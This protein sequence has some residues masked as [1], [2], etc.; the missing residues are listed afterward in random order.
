MQQPTSAVDCN[1]DVLDEIFTSWAADTRAHDTCLDTDG[2]D[3][4]TPN[5]PGKQEHDGDDDSNHNPPIDETASSDTASQNTSL[6]VV[7]PVSVASP[8]IEF[9]IPAFAEFSDQ[10]NRRALIDHFT[11][12]LSHL[13]VLR[14]D[15]GNPFQRLVLPLSQKSTAVSNSIFAL[16]SAHLEHRG[17]HNSERSVYFHNKAINGLAA[18]IAKGCDANR[19]ELL[20][21]IILL[22]YYE[23]VSYARYPVVW[24][25]SL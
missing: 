5:D 13:I 10:A 1:Q 4:I 9:I 3:F 23:V 18:L 2:L 8:T 16:A 11:N 6:A 24:E 20:A 14:E 17:V 12:V 22:I 15:E 21:A 25:S 7:G 19:N